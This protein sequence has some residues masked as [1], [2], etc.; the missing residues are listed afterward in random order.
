MAY[1]SSFCEKYAFYLICGK[2]ILKTGKKG[3]DNTESLV[4]NIILYQNGLFCPF[5]LIYVVGNEL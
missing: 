4:Y 1:F 3:I 2:N 5:V